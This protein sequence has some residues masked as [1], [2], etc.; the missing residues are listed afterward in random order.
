MY[1]KIFEPCLL[2]SISRFRFFLPTVLPTLNV[3]Q[4]KEQFL[5]P[6]PGTELPPYQGWA[7]TDWSVTSGTGLT[8]MP[9]CRCW[10]KRCKLMEN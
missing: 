5:E 9:E 4:V 8:T 2:I 7:L 6:Y 3:T 10:T 1:K